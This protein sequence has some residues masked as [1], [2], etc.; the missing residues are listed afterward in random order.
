MRTSLT[1]SAEP[2]PAP[3]TTDLFPTWRCPACGDDL[4][5]SADSATGWF[6][7]CES[8][9]ERV[10]CRQGRPQF[11]SGYRPEGFPV[12]RRDHLEALTDGH[13]W[14]AARERLLARCLDRWIERWAPPG[15]PRTALEI[16]CGTGR[17]LPVLAERFPRV[18]AVDAYDESLQVAARRLENEPGKTSVALAQ[19][20][21]HRIPL[22]DGTFDLTVA[23]DVLEHLDDERPALAELHRLTRPGGGLLVSVPA[24]PALWSELDRVA[25]H[26]RRYRRRPL[27]DL[28][29]ETGW[30]VLHHTHYQALLL[31]LVWLTRRGLAPLQGV[32]RRP[33]SWLGAALGAVNAFEVRA[34]SRW[35]LPWGSSL[36]AVAR[37]EP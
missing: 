14:F 22:P 10:A 1:M 33:P 31:P 20:D 34:F 16:G 8:C 23:L 11:A 13:F 3:T 9:G 27:S 32:E 30:R 21:L 5:P 35:R 17:L 26:H 37:R 7:A 19:A 4:P 24:L 25:G 12:E 18:V 28:L 15:S 36:V 2:L 6:P 29:A